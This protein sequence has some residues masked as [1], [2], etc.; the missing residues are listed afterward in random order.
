VLLPG[1]D[2]AQAVRVGEQVLLMLEQPVHLGDSTVDLSGAL[3]VAC[4]PEHA[5]DAVTLLTRAEVAMYEAKHRRIGTMVYDPAIDSGSAQS[6]SLLGE[7]RRALLRDELR[8]FLQPKLGVGGR[9]LIGAEALV[10]WQ[11]PERGLVPPMQ[12]IPFAEETGFIHELTL[13]VVQD[14]A[15]VCAEWRSR[16]LD[17]KLSVNLSTH[18]LMK[19]DLL[20]RLTQRLA[21][22]GVPPQSLC[23]EITESAIMSDPQRALQTLKALSAHGFK[24][25]IDD[26]GTGYSSYAT[27]K[28][29]PV[30]ELKID[31][32]FVR[33]ME[34]EPK[35][36]M[37]VRSIIEVAHNLGLSVVAEG[38]ENQA[39]LEQLDALGCDEAQGWH[40]GKPMPTGDFVKWADQPRAG[41]VASVAEVAAG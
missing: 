36:A 14:A 24:L 29:L 2:P 21:R 22:H 35:D 28:N 8:L 11:H 20:D 15:R 4:H 7:M 40:I 41:L 33:A 32:S 26:F 3:G 19:P 9:T 6:L 30:D 27:L 39:I 38:V 12:F 1:C 25:S 31:M 34:K 37:I 18:D 23:L 5:Q 13:W 17:L 16:G 10:R